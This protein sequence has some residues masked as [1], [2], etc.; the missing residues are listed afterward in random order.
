VLTRDAMGAW[1]QRA[2]VKASS[3]AQDRFGTTVALSGDGDTLAVSA[4]D[5]DSNATG[6]GGDQTNNSVFNSGAVYL[7]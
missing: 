5:E 7:Y 6:I 3:P 4:L 1:S 2:Y